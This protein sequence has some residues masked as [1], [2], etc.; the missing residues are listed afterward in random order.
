MIKRALFFTTFLLLA[1]SFFADNIHHRYINIEGS[2]Y[3]TDHYEFLM[4]NFTL[5]AGAAGYI[6][7]RSRNNAA[8][9]LNFT[10]SPAIGSN[11]YQY[12]L[13]TSLF[14]NED[15]FEIIT[16]DLFFNNID[17]VYEYTRTLF[18]NA[19]LYIPL[20]TAEELNEWKNKWIYLRASFDY[21]ITFYLLKSDGLYEGVA[22][23]DNNIPPVVFDPI[24]H[25]VIAMPGATVGVEFQILDFLSLE[26]NLQVSWGDTRSNLFINV[27]AGLELKFPIKLDNIAI[28]PYGVFI[29]P[30]NVS[31][32]FSDF[33]LF[34]F[35]AG[36]QLCARAGRNGAFFIDVNYTFSV[37][38]AVMHNPY[39]ATTNQLYPNPPVIH[40]NRSVIGIGIGYKFG[41]FDRR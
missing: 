12:V 32:I 39:L 13:K 18:Q 16:M 5:E 11:N 3:I 6:V 37:S 4:E 33:P 29:Y 41:F 20:N 30:M 23:Y 40:Y 28:V 17:E 34:A 2:A 7:T 27:A 22:L 35:G 8:H 15:G 24:G 14:R 25:E 21:P 9:T 10:V 19:A 38:D 36:I 26:L 31:P 1:A